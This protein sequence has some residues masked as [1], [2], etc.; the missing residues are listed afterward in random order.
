MPTKSGRYHRLNRAIEAR[1]AKGLSQTDI[2]DAVGT[3][4]FNIHRVEC[5]HRLAPLWMAVR[6]IK[7]LPELELED[8]LPR[9]KP[10][11]AA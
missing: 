8:F 1:Q 6:W 10:Q 4:K 5:G 11:K 2:A 3:T 9:K 7:F